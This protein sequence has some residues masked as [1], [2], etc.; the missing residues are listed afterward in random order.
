MTTITH[1]ISNNTRTLQT[2]KRNRPIRHT[3]KHHPINQQ[4]QIV[5]QKRSRAEQ[6]E[7]RGGHFPRS[8]TKQ[9]LESPHGVSVGQP[10]RN[11]PFLTHDQGCIPCGGISNRA[12]VIE[13]IRKAFL[14]PTPV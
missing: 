13:R 12:A 14:S 7:R 4:D 10:R 6:G 5:G 2:G 8:G 1:S 9:R 11:A 3:A